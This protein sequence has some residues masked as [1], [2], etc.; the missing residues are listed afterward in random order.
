MKLT[1]IAD[2]GHGEKFETELFVEERLTTSKYEL[3][4]LLRREIHYMADIVTREV[5]NKIIPESTAEIFARSLAD[6]E[7]NTQQK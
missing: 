5:V 7:R 6:H 1:L 4:K 2:L 3:N